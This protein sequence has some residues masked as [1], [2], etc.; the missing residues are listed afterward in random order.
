[1]IGRVGRPPATVHLQFGA[2]TLVPHERLLLKDGQPL[3]L[4]PK[5][6]DLLSFF[7]SN[8]GRL[9]TKD[10]I[11][12]AVWPDAIVEESNLAYHVSAIRKALGDG[13]DPDPFVETVP[14][15]GYR[16]IAPVVRV[17]DVSSPV[18]SSVPLQRFQ[19]PSWGRPAASA[20]FSISPNGH[21]LILAIQGEDGA[22]MLWLRML[23]E[24]TPHPIFGSEGFIM[25]PPI[26][27]PR[28]DAIAFG[29]G[30]WLKRVTLAGGLPRNVC[31]FP[32]L[33]VGGSWNRDDVILV[34]NPR[35]PLLRCPA[36]GGHAT[37]VTR[38]AGPREMHLMPAFLSDGRHFI[39]LRIY[40]DAPERSGIC[41]GHLDGRSSADDDVRLLETGFNAVPVP[42]SEA[43]PGAIVFMR[44]GALFAQRFDD[45]R[46]ALRGAPVR[47]ADQV[48]SFL[49]GGFFSAS[50]RIL[51]YRAPDP[52]YQLAWFDR[53]GRQL[54]RVGAPEPVAGLALSPDDG[55]ALV[56]RH[57]PH[58][59]VDQR[60]WLLDLQRDANPQ[61]LTFGSAIALW[62]SWISNDRFAYGFGG[63]D[64]HVYEQTLGGKARLW[65]HG[66]GT[67]G[68]TTTCDGRVAVF[69]SAP[70]PPT[71]TD[72]WVW[73]MH[74]PSE[75]MP[76]VVREGDQNQA[77]L[78]PDGRWLAYVSNETGRY[79]VLV[80]PFRYNSATGEASVGESLSISN[81][82]GFAPRWR[83]DVKELFYLKLDGSVMAVD[84]H[85]T[86]GPAAG[87]GQRLFMLPDVFHE[88]GIS[89]DGGRFLCAV[90]TAPT[91]PLHIVQNWQSLLPE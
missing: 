12:H 14:K 29:H 84:V 40:R 69:A 61:P 9:L 3:A 80:A 21:H 54:H 13:A 73:T 11:L 44:D 43:G 42:E 1:M 67:S 90:P 16:F 66:G 60:L 50:P 7:A 85:E 38:T 48:G 6:F 33:A 64:S 5:A 36:S 58:N 63:G 47:L 49:D 18:P 24:P 55:R 35:G 8:P 26:W 15:R 81:G 31:E 89:R 72:L 71:R 59:A 52:L 65:F 39:Y 53:D 91:P 37:P 28:S 34:G 30:G 76:L 78:S 20:T 17:G 56:V 19:E 75:G 46:I 25:P 22:A 10:E 62:P 57:A 74:G 77:Q 79:E 68:V 87:S 51:V 45:Q 82:G 32:D 27:S 2:V 88:W 86:S 70:T 41:V 83:S 23:S 4:T